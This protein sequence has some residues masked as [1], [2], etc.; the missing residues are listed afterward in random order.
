MMKPT[1]TSSSSQAPGL[2]ESDVALLFQIMQPRDLSE[3]G[4][5][6]MHRM[7]L[8]VARLLAERQQG[9][10]S[11]RGQADFVYEIDLSLPLAPLES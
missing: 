9:N 2:T 7:Q 5:P 11:L 6:Q 8:Y 10:L 1:L 3:T 4:R